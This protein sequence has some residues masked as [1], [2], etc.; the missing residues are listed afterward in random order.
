MTSV[1]RRLSTVLDIADENAAL[2]HASE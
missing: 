2:G 1:D